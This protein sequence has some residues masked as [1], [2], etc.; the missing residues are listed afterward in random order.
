MTVKQFRIKFAK[1]T[2]TWEVWLDPALLVL[3]SEEAAA[4]LGCTGP[5]VPPWG[6]TE[7]AKH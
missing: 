4:V 6:A 2:L 1:T 7:K 5:S 3:H